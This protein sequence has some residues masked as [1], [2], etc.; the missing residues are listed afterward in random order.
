MVNGACYSK[1]GEVKLYIDKGSDVKSIYGE[2]ISITVPAYTLDTLTKKY[3]FEPDFIKID[4]EGAE[5]KVLIGAR[6][7]IKKYHP[8]LI[9]EVWNE[10]IDFVVNFLEKFGYRRQVIESW[11]PCK[12]LYF[13]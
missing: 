5:K 10:N 11:K 4:V 9:V 7:T 2:G 8:K 13:F 1:N 6:K 12:I 3:N